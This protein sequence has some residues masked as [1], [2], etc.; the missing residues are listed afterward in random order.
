MRAP[1]QI[2]FPNGRFFLTRDDYEGSRT[3]LAE[4]KVMNERTLVAVHGYSGDA[5]Q[6]RWFLPLYEHH[7]CSVVI[8]SPDNARISEMGPHI[9]RFGGVRAYIGPES[10]ER[11]QIHL[12]MLLEYSDFQYFLAND[13]DSFCLSPEIPKYLYGEDV[14]WSN[15]V[16]DMMHHRPDNYTWP[17]LA[18]QPPYFFSRNILQQLVDIAPTVACDPQTPFIDWCMMA[19]SIA[20]KIPHKNFTDGISCPSVDSHSLGVMRDHVRTQGKVMVHSVKQ[21]QV[22]MMLMADRNYYRRTHKV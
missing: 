21:N 5:T 18:F 19:W 16:S 20:G 14:L 8:L 12:K 22:K 15:E 7:K 11:Q 3:W 17:R 10:L 6:I 2:F 4:E 1:Q 9:C 13:A